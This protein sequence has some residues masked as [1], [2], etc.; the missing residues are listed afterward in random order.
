MCVRDHPGEVS[1]LWRRRSC[2]S[3]K[4]CGDLLKGKWH[5]CK[6][7]GCGPWQEYSLEKAP[8]KKK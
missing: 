6:E 7:P 3:C 8:A 4:R 5:L 2:Y 1:V